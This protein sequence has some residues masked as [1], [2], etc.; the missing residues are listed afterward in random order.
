MIGDTAN[1]DNLTRTSNLRW[2]EA[3]RELA[4]FDVEGLP[5]PTVSI[6]HLIA[7]EQTGRAQDV[8]DVHVLPEMQRLRDAR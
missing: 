7:S 2:D 1:V 8:A 4:V 6:A 3:E 5:L